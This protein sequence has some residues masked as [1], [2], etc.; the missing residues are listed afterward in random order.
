M[1][2]I[3]AIIICFLSTV[4]LFAQYAL[5]VK[6]QILLAGNVGE[7]RASHFHAGIDIKATEG[8][9]SDID[10][11][12][13][14]YISRIGVSP[15]GYGN[16]LYVTHPNG[17]TSV[18]AHLHAFAPE[19]QKW[20]EQNQYAQRTFR[21]N[22]YPTQSQFPVRKGQTIGYMGNSGS[23]SG[24]H[25]H[26]EIRNQQHQPLNICHLNLFKIKDTIPPTLFKVV[27]YEADTTMGIVHFHPKDTMVVGKGHNQN[28]VLRTNKNF[29]L[30]YELI[31]HKNLVANTFGIY[32]LE[33]KINGKTNFQFE[34]PHTD[35]STTKYVKAFVQYEMNRRNRNHVIRAYVAKNNRLRIYKNVQNRGVITP[36]DSVMNISVALTDD[37]Q[38]TRTVNFKVQ[39]DYSSPPHKDTT[40]VGYIIRWN[41]HTTIQD[42]YM[43]VKIPQEAV[44][45]DLFL[46]FEYDTIRKEYVLGN[47]DYPLHL[48][49]DV[50]IPSDMVPPK[51]LLKSTNSST[52]AMLKPSEN[53]HH[54]AKIYTMGNYKIVQDTL[55]PTIKYLG[56]RDNAI[57]FTVKDNLSGIDN[58]SIEVNGRWVLAEWDPKRNRLSYFVQRNRTAVNNSVRV[59]LVDYCGNSREQTYNIKW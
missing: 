27:L 35:Y 2:S 53:H 46:P 57:C 54:T 17:Y 51:A 16:V 20:V 15:T 6:H 55:P 28:L 23:S 34:I 50:K 49:V 21:I 47:P 7:V 59:T 40:T 29:Y 3:V 30:V 19:I 39:R 24:P 12:E 8:I 38:N 43:E 32:A 1:K 22:L 33:Q 41:K 5:P 45:D 52:V 11:I 25:L 4:S 31:D 18:Y 58:Y 44:Y 48:P 13:R 9:G 37:S 10:A 14:G 56:L 36:P 26:I 42:R